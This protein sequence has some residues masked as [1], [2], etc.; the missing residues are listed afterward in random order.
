MKFSAIKDKI[1]NLGNIKSLSEIKKVGLRICR[2]TKTG[3]YWLIEEEFLKPVFRSPRES[4]NITVEL[5][6]LKLKVLICPFSKTDLNN[7]KVLQYI[8]W[9]E[10]QKYQNKPTCKNRKG[11]W[12]LTRESARLFVQMS[13]NDV[14]KFYFSER[15]TLADARLYT[16]NI[17]SRFK[18]V[19]KE[20]DLA[21]SL[22]STLT[23][24]SLELSG[25][26]NLGEGALDFKVYEAE[27]T[28]LLD[29]RLLNQLVEIV[30]CEKVP[31]Y[32]YFVENCKREIKS[33]FQE[34]GINP[35]MPI[36]V[37]EPSP[38]PDR[39]ILDDYIFSILKLTDQERKEVY[40]AVC[41]LVKNRLE[42]ARNV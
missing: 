11:W 26:E 15:D 1:Q 23:F 24:L 39:K 10:K 42:K 34:S 28:Y 35:K 12:L 27:D 25:R 13:F 30:P 18:T 37:Q 4:K 3:D 40:W 7:K 6:K 36:T 20:S 14:F 9:G 2:N 22:N 33:I 41:E 19:I 16:I 21:N 8:Q 29:P 31:Y 38:L 17:K 32:N 5:D